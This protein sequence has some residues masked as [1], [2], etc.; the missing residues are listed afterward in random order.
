MTLVR[1]NES[2]NNIESLV[3]IHF[4]TDLSLDIKTHTRLLPRFHHTPQLLHRR[5]RNRLSGAHFLERFS[6]FDPC[7]EEHQ[8]AVD[9]GAVDELVDVAGVDRLRRLQ[10]GRADAVARWNAAKRDVVTKHHNLHRHHFFGLKIDIKKTKKSLD[11]EGCLLVTLCP[12]C[13]HEIGC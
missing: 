2:L 7:D 11:F 1:G 13:L 8:V 5:R 3:E 10:A 12:M 6:P 4:Q 9:F